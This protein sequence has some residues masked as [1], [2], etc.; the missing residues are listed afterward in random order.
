VTIATQFIGP[1][2]A[3]IAW[4]LFILVWMYALR[5]PAMRKA[6]MKL[7]PNAPRGEQMSQLP[8]H[9]RWKSDNYSHLLEQ[10]TLFYALA[11]SLA[12][13]GV[14]TQTSLT[15]AW[16]YVIVRIAHSLVQVLINK[17]ELRFVLFVMSNIPLLWLTLIAVSAFM[18]V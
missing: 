11:L 17:I 13:L 12:L 15:L 1:V 4:T 14:Q 18:K 5:L 9:V 10:P 3:L 8:P 16:V 6:R 7:D 2:L